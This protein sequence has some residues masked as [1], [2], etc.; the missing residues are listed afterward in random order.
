MATEDR[1]ERERQQR[2]LGI[3]KAAEQVF[4]AKGFDSATM[5]EI[6]VAAEFTKRTVYSYFASKDDL[7]AAV[8]LHHLQTLV[9]WFGQAVAQPVSGL[10]Q[11]C[12][13][14]DAW[15]RFARE[16]TSGFQLM[17]TFRLQPVLGG[18][19]TNRQAAL[20]LN[21]Q[22]FAQV[23]GAFVRGLA[24]GSVRP[25][26][27]PRAAALFVISASSGVLSAVAANAHQLGESTQLQPGEFI[28]FAMDRIGDSFRP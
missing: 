7:Q 5:D 10:D 23:V 25:G 1:Q 27:D 9:D 13:I 18:E 12:L 15:V 24:D 17:A 2:R 21:Q 28:Q 8:M 3:M 22:I 11:V 4:L 19:A 20:A 6:A 26:I 14:G 16:E